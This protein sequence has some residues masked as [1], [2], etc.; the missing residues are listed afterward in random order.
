MRFSLVR[1]KSKI[2]DLKL[3]I[4][5]SQVQLTLYLQGVK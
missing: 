2:V 4:K 1:H 5:V 3:Y